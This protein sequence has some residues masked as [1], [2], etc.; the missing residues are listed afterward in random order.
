MNIDVSNIKLIAMRE[1]SQKVR[2]RSFVII[3][4]I[5]V[6]VVLALVLAPT[7]ISAIFGD[8]NNG[9][10]VAI[11]Q[12]VDG[13][14]S[15]DT[16]SALQDYV[17]RFGQQDQVE[18]ALA[19]DDDP[20]NVLDQDGV[21]GVLD[22][23]RDGSG[24]L[25]FV[26]T[27]DDGDYDQAAVVTYSAIASLSLEDSLNQA[28]IEGPDVDR[29]LAP[30]QV[31]VQSVS[32]ESAA[33]N[34]ATEDNFR[35]GVA[36]VS[37][38]ALYMV[39]LIYGMWVAQGV[40]VEKSSRI[41]EIMVNAT[42]PTDLMFGKIIGIGMAGLTQVVPMLLVAGIGLVSQRW[43][44]DLLNVT[45]INLGGIDFGTLS[46]TLVTFFLI[47]FLLGFLLYAS[48]YAGV[49]SLVSRQ[50]DIQTV[51]TPLTF[52]VIAGFFGALFTLGAPD[53]M[54]A[55]VI[56]IIPFTSPMAMVPRILLG[57]PDAWEIA[58][59]IAL[60]AVS[61]YLAVILAARTYRMGVLMYG[62][63]PS[64]K[65]IFQRDTIRTAR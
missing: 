43:L 44:A 10:R 35:Y 42:S 53:S 58:L 51:M 15:N 49:G 21:D 31:T 23:T 17:T 37:A 48:L 38:V 20:T 59:S 33:S 9:E 29:I 7:V 12:V 39:M 14:N 63:K 52:A 24:T 61:A 13:S 28:G 5:Q 50:E 1:W 2:E 11:V 60:L 41:M 3:T 22:V 30:P 56:A 47:Y 19:T 8:D 40:V 45:G 27:N 16:V 36:Y 18:Y 57:D 65:V 64:L 25:S 6:A 26:Y 46:V 32:G 55:R 4:A 34:E 62:Q 54:V